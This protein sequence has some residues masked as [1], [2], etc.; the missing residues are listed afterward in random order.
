MVY[1][2]GLRMTVLLKNRER[3]FCIF[4]RNETE[5]EYY[6]NRTATTAGLIQA[7]V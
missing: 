2:V 3:F 5:G 6:E 4:S 7:G 1:G